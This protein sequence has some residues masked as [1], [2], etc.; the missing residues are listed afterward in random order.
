MLTAEHLKIVFCFADM[1]KF[2]LI[3]V[4]ITVVQVVVGPPVTQK[5]GGSE[6]ANEENEINENDHMV[7]H[8]YSMESYGIYQTMKIQLVT[9]LAYQ[10]QMTYFVLDTKM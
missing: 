4:L 10:S 1:T 3:L 5:K 2:G 6:N 9:K 7:S 8:M